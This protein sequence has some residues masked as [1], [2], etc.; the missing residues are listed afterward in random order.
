[1]FDFNGLWQKCGNTVP[2]IS[3]RFLKRSPHLFGALAFLIAVPA[4]ALAT[5]FPICG[6]GK[7][8][9]CVVDGDT[10]WLNGEKIRP[11]GFDAPE[12]GKPNCHRPAA[13]A[14]ES[15]AELAR[16][17][18]GAQ[19]GIERH[20]MSFNRRLARVTVNGADLATLM[21]RAGRARAYVPGEAPWC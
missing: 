9:T 5:D 16:L 12:M 8:I 7:R 15:R 17:L 20:G 10:F 6:S 18:S 4:P 11:E 3:L 1:M 14:V 2:L 19:L 21:I 13:G